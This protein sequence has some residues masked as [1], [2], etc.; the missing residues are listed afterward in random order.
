[1]ALPPDN[2]IAFP[3]KFQK[4]LAMTQSFHI[5]RVNDVS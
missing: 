4:V 2:A 5:I 1:M 3:V